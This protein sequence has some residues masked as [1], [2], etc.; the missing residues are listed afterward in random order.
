MTILS[1]RIR[2]SLIVACC[3]WNRPEQPQCRGPRFWW[4]EKWRGTLRTGMPASRVARM[5]FELASGTY[6][7]V[8]L[9]SPLTSG[10]RL[11]SAV[12]V[13]TF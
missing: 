11:T 10:C 4:P 9:L 2:A 13:V 1:T 6:P 8:Q 3:P 12:A 5:V 7:E